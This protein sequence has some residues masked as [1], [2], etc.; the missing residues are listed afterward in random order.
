MIPV[1]HNVT[2]IYRFNSVIFYLKIFIEQNIYKK[3]YNIYKWFIGVFK[4]NI[5]SNSM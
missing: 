1:N 4:N 5:Y 2:I 3:N